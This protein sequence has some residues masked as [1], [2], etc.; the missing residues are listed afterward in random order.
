[1][2][3]GHTSSANLASDDDR[4]LLDERRPI[5]DNERGQALTEYT[6][7]LAFVS[8]AALAVSPIGQWVLAA[9]GR[10]GADL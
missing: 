4:S 6:L 3:E 7:V 9:F 2:F 5:D 1:M 10:V 8:I